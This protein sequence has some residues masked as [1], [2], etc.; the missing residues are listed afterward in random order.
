MMITF[1]AYYQNISYSSSANCWVAAQHQLIK[2]EN[3]ENKTLN[4][5]MNQ[6]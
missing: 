2:R 4:C 1:F 5:R 6:E 3:N